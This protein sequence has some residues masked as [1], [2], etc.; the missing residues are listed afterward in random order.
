MT[1]ERRPDAPGLPLAELL[2]GASGVVTGVALDSRRV[3]PGDL[4]VG[5][6][7]ARAH[8]A[9]FA[10]AAAEAGA[11]ALLTDADGAA[12]A[13]GSGLPVVVV[14]DPRVE[15]A[16]IAARVY[17]RPGDRLDLFGVTGTNGKTSTVF[18]LE[19]ALAA[20]GRHVATIGT[21]GFRI[22][23]R[24][25]DA[26]RSTITTPES[27]DV[28]ALLAQ[29]LGEG[30]DTVAM[31]VSSHALALHRVDGLTFAAAAFTMFGQDHLE[32]HHTLEDYFAAKARLFLDGRA[33][34][35]VIN[36]ADPWGARLAGMVRADGSTRLVTTLAA[37]AQYRV[38]EAHPRPDGGWRVVLAYPGGWTTFSLSMLGEFNVANAVT[39]LAMVGARGL[40]VDAAAAGL[41]SAQ[42][43]GRMQ[44]VDL[45]AGA[46]H[47]VVDFAH[48]PQAVASAL[49]ALPASGRRIAVLGAG[50][51]RDTTKRG[52]MGEAAAAAA[53]VVIVT[54]D[55]PRT[56]E[57]AA[58]R[59][60]LLAGARDRG[61]Q[62]IDGGDR[63]EAIAL[64][65]TM[66]RTGDWVAVL[67]KGHERGQDIGGRISPFD[68]VAVVREIW[69][70]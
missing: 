16:S 13:A 34:V 30:V 25:L 56:E 55:N 36:S 38:L 44:R 22:G 39:A 3:G 48:T 50:G 29:M 17:G 66:A 49:A 47:V 4:Y 67:G 19:A 61:A 8:G 64:A 68:D 37:D 1:G 6:R 69:E 60:A 31:E 42:V 63:R 26:E 58:I 41:A 46:P 11:L 62:V 51:D 59:A 40:D 15:M 28:Q 32:F 65:L 33:E 9:A 45:G 27:P 18:L 43:P 53:D 5:L 24:L 54:D 7:G 20:L 12:L 35:A 52:P 10:V 57:P 23:G 2:P 21:I 14:D 70:D